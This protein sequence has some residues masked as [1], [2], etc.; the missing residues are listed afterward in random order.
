MQIYVPPRNRTIGTIDALG[1]VGLLGFAVARWVPIATL[2]PFWG[3]S[4][5]KLTGWPCPGCG[6]TRVADRF[7]HFHWLRALQA[8][9]LGTLAAAGFAAAM[10]ASLVHL[11]FAVPLPELVLTEKEWA[12]V[13]WAMVAGIILNY[14]FVAYAFRVLHWS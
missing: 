7:A 4:W 6:L 12:R 8:N 2:V 14:A 9:P 5:R 10:V 1:L 11:I 3:C 13:R